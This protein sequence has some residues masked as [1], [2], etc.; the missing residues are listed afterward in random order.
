M[1]ASPVAADGKLYFASEEGEVY[2]LKTGPKYELLAINPMGEAIMATP[3]ISDN[4]L[5]IR[6]QHH[7]FGIQDENREL[8][9]QV[10]LTSAIF[11]NTRTL[12]VILPADYY[13]PENLQQRYA[14]LYFNDGFAV[15]KP[16]G[17]NAPQTIYR[18]MREGAIPPVIVV[19]IDNA[20][21]VEN[22]TVAD[23]TNEYLPYPDKSEPL[24]PNPRGKLYPE[25]LVKEV[26]PLINQKYR[27]RTEATHT[28]IAGASYGGV[29]ALYTVMNK[30]NVFGRLLLES[31]PLFLSDYKLLEQARKF[32]QL[33]G[34]VYIGI[35]TKETDDDELNRTAEPSMKELQSIILKNSPQTMTKLVVEEGASHNSST[36][37][38][39]LPVALKFLLSK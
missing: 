31:T 27:T 26:I 29:A 7:V 24:A 33:P 22:G 32:K 3:A 21:T 1:S 14:V 38:K 11:G 15:F 34:R 2:V 25:F 28:G 5:I 23:R 39:R 36:W 16:T 30:P 20:A 19:G 4:L 18:Q 6:G 8:I 13:K 12:R 10:E 35:G 9:E 17:W 37:G